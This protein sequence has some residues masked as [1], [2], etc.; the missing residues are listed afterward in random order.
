MYI[1]CVPKVQN[2]PPGTYLAYH[3][4]Y[5]FSLSSNRVWGSQLFV[6]ESIFSDVERQ[7]FVCAIKLSTIISNCVCPATGS[8]FY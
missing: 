7:A 4:S 3:V 2:E 1:I 6:T 8:P 5:V